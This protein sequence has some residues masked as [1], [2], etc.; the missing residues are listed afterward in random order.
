MSDFHNFSDPKVVLLTF[1]FRKSFYTSKDIKQNGGENCA[2][3]EK[4]E[5]PVCEPVI[6]V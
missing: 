4:F 2:K 3:T 5:I 6:I 1:Y